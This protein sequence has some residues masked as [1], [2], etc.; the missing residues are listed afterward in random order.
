MKKHGER[1]CIA[2]SCSRCETQGARL[3][4]EEMNNKE[5]MEMNGLT[6]GD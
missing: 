2:W 6:D 1:M 5:D 3:H 4:G